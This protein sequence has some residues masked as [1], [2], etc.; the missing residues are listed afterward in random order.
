M[1]RRLAVGVVME[2]SAGSW[3]LMV[4]GFVSAC[5]LTRELDDGLTH[6][7]HL[8]QFHKPEVTELRRILRL[9][10]L[11]LL[12]RF[13]ATSPMQQ[14]VILKK[15][16]KFQKLGNMRCGAWYRSALCLPMHTSFTFMISAVVLAE[17]IKHY[18]RLQS[19]EHTTVAKGC[20][21]RH[22]AIR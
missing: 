9:S 22:L 6:L 5:Q 18:G 15:K 3:Y 8:R 11:S 14:H 16:L 4:S 13:A 1:E 19:A 17:F 7:R 12:L 20:Q 10:H 21:C 2:V